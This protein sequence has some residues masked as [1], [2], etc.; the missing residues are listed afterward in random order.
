MASSKIAWSGSPSARAIIKSLVGSPAV[1]DDGWRHMHASPHEFNS[2]SRRATARAHQTTQ[3][4]AAP[5][6]D[7]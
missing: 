4:A 3:V 2:K 7:E 1:F 5:V 6:S